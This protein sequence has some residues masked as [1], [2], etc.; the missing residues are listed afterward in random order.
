VDLTRSYERFV[1]PDVAAR[2]DF[3]ETRDAASV[4]AAAH[5][6]PWSD[7]LGVLGAFALTLDDLVSPGRNKS[8]VAAGI[9]RRFRVLGWRETALE[10]ETTATLRVLPYREAGE[11]EVRVRTTTT[12]APGH[13]VDNVKDRV[14]LDVEWNAKDGNLD[15]DLANFRA[16]HDAGMVNVGVLV[17]R[18]HART[19]YA[20]NV[21]AA[22]TGR[23]RTGPGGRPVVLLGT[24][25]TTNL[26][27]LVPRLERGDAGGC[28][29]L[30]VAITDRC[31]VPGPGDPDLPPPTADALALLPFDDL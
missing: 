14:A 2:Y 25:T 26:E 13:L 15:R 22:L 18:S 8:D 9:D 1:P 24:S 21:L 23:Q 16:L 27:K 28:P 11:R 4:L 19:R 29:V 12:H 5:P 20:A 17:T 7:I 3:A 30:A 31:Y 6:G 10:I